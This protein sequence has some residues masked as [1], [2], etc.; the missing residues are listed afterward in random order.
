[1]T[2]LIRPRIEAPN[3]LLR[4]GAYVKALVEYANIAAAHPELGWML[5]YNLQLAQA[6]LT[7]KLRQRARKIHQQ[8][9]VEFAREQASRNGLQL[10]LKSSRSMTSNPEW[11]RVDVCVFPPQEAEHLTVKIRL[12]G[13]QIELSPQVDFET[14]SASLFLWCDGLSG[15]LDVEQNHILGEAK[16]SNSALAFEAY[17]LENSSVVVQHE[18]LT[19]GASALGG[20]LQGLDSSLAEQRTKHLKRMLFSSELISKQQANYVKHC[21]ESFV[22]THL[23]LGLQAPVVVLD[24]KFRVASRDMLSEGIKFNLEGVKL[25]CGLY[26]LFGW[27]LD[28]GQNI[29]CMALKMNVGHLGEQG[30]VELLDS[31][32]IRYD[33]KDVSDL[34]GATADKSNS[35]YGFVAAVKA[36]KALDASPNTQASVSFVIKDKTGKYFEEALSVDTLDPNNESLQTLLG[37]IPST[38]PSK[39]ECDLYYRDVFELY[40]KHSQSDYEYSDIQIGESFQ[41]S[42]HDKGDGV[43]VVIP[44]Y[45]NTRFEVTQIPLLSTYRE[46]WAEI[47]FAVDDPSIYNE[48]KANCTRLGAL[49]GVPIRLVVPE[50][51]LGFA[52]INNLAAKLAVSEHVLFLNSDCFVSQAQPVLKGLE[53]L[54]NSDA[55]AVGFRLL[56]ADEKIQHDG[57]SCGVWNSDPAFLINEHPGIGTPIELVS[58]DEFM[59]Q[60]CMLTAACLLIRKSIFESVGGFSTQY[61]RGDFEDS[62]L[63]L[64]LI[65]SGKK[66]AIVK[67]NNIFHLERQ[68]IG[69]QAGWLKQKITLINSYLY[70]RQW[71]R[72]L[73]SRLPKLEILQ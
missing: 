16:A 50:R 26:V 60:S 44:L 5:E 64:K 30:T 72:V 17:R 9:I 38:N 68:T 6:R 24:Q 52:G 27:V 12:Y 39:Q 11:W 3:L 49:Y 32:L 58:R 62:D 61:V 8:P 10:D 29:D 13:E 22:E 33:R 40:A 4:Q 19:N 36:K 63:C 1:M 51:N 37:L 43:S 21:Y 46:L 53:Y 70:T 14:G 67:T 56:Y 55:G 48:V 71:S 2:N 42:R 47:I 35:R 23:N 15:S 65:Q 20:S 28:R 59:N 66:L 45:G 41:Q 73:S 31:K 57:M 25:F 69:D 54:K 18:L 7:E 34:Y